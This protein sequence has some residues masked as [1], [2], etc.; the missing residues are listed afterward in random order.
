[1]NK[2]H[3]FEFFLVLIVLL[4]VAPCSYAGSDRLIMSMSAQR[5]DQ[6]D[7]VYVRFLGPDGA[8]LESNVLSR[9]V[10]RVQDCSSGSILKIIDDYK[11]GYAP[12]NMLV[13]IYLYPQ[14][15]KNKTLCFSIPSIGKIEQG[16][17]PSANNGRTFQFKVVP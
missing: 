6:E 10:I 13:G 14:A 2:S 16:L 11:I 7:L 5:M 4:W 3:L 17:N 8:A 12:K 1:M 15:W 9:M